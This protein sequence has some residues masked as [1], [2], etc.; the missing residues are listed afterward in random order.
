MQFCR[1]VFS[2]FTDDDDDDDADDGYDDGCDDGD[3][4]GCDEADDGYD[5]GDDDGDDDDGCDEGDDGDATKVTSFNLSFN[6]FNQHR[7]DPEQRQSASLF[8]V[9]HCISNQD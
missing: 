4:D 5:D 1:D 6:P 8:V 2:Q 3:D 9:E 7:D